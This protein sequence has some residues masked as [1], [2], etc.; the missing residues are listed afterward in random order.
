ML[1]ALRQ[2]AR[3]RQFAHRRRDWAVVKLSANKRRTGRARKK[4]R[5]QVGAELQDAGSQKA[6]DQEVGGPV[7]AADVKENEAKIETELKSSQPEIG[8]P[9]QFE[10]PGQLSGEHAQADLVAQS[11][12]ADAKPE[13][14]PKSG[15][16]RVAENRE[17]VFESFTKMNDSV[18]SLDGVKKAA[19]WY[20]ETSEKIAHQALEFQE[21]A[22]GWAK[23]TP[24][25]PLFEAQHSIARKLVERSASAARTLWQIPNQ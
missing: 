5:D 18:F 16:K 23:D 8:A 3:E 7:E 19:A 15:G 11:K 2:F 25:A 10:Q 20:I 14:G 1:P 9:P 24:F 22:T 12:P 6:P 4:Q 13:A 21:R 17:G